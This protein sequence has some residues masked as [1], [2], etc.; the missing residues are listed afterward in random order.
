MEGG[1]ADDTGERLWSNEKGVY[2]RSQKTENIMWK[3][4]FHRPL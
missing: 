2:C 4:Y 1:G 3:L